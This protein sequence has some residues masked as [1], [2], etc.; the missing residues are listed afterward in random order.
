MRALCEEE[1]CRKA[2]ALE[3]N[4]VLLGSGMSGGGAGGYS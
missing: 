4:E 2:T 3:R 1:I